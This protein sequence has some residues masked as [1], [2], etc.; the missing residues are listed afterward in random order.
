MS[1]ILYFLYLYL[2]IYTGYIFVLAIRNFKDSPFMIEKKYSIHDDVKHNFGV[3]IYSHNNK[4]GLEKLISQ[5]K[6]Q[7]YPLGCFKVYAILDNCNDG[8]EL[9]FE[10]DKYIHVLNIQD[11]GTLGKSQSI[12]MLLE[13]IKKDD[14]IDAYIFIDATRRIESNFL[15]LANAAI[16]ANDAVTGEVNIDRANLDIVDKI[17]AVYKKYIANF[18]KQARTLC[19]LATTVDSGLFIIRKYIMDELEDFDFKDINSELEFSIVLTK[20]GHKCVYNPNI[21]SYIY[22]QD[23]TF[24]NPKLTKKF[25]LLKDNFTNLKTTNFA[26]IEQVCSLLNPNFWMVFAGYLLLIWY[27]YNFTFAV[28]C[29]TVIYS[30]IVLLVV[31]GLSLWNSKLTAK[32]IVMLMLHPLYSICHIIWNLPP[33]RYIIRKLGANTDKDVDKLSIDAAVQTKHGDRTCKLEFISTESGLA[34]IRFIYKNKKYTTDSH[35]RMIDALQQ[36]KSKM[37]DYGLILKICS[38]C[39]KFTSVAD[40]TA[41]MLKGQCHNDYPSPLLLEP[42][43]TLIW[44]SCSCFEPAQINSLIEEIAKEVEEQKEV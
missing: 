5:L 44:N 2:I 24:K 29:K 31:L 7:D 40:G 37:S 30:A 14:T 34:K 39:S 43:P 1:V 41:N 25:E 33:V 28:R 3:I 38:C 27:S 19:G 17:K 32:E 20:M 23:C 26:F 9:L 35:L 6:M 11:V 8:S 18:L 36:L 10:N 12:S 13:E 15:T 16:E 4:V 22:G 21:Q 42:K